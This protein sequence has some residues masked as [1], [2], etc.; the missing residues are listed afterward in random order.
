M[1]GYIL[2]HV[3]E[4]ENYT[5]NVYQPILSPEERERRMK[6]IYKAAENL[7][8]SRLHESF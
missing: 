1:E 4:R 5:T 3:I 2:T 7:L 6:N 8:K